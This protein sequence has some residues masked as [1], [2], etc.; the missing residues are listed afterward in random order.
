M[1]FIHLCLGNERPSINNPIV[2]PSLLLEA[3]KNGGAILDVRAANRGRIIGPSVQA[4]IGLGRIRNS[5]CSLAHSES[6]AWSENALQ[7][8]R[9]KSSLHT[10]CDAHV[11]G[12]AMREAEGLNKSSFCS[13]TSASDM[14]DARFYA[15]LIRKYFS[16]RSRDRFAP[17]SVKKTDFAFV[18]GSE[19]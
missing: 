13:G 3:G 5:H 17:V 10:I 12:S 16:N 18:A 6:G 4:D 14:P 11:R 9:S 15:E 1:A 19:M 2:K 7:R 8:R